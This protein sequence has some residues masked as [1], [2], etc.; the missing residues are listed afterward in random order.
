[1]PLTETIYQKSPV[2]IQNILISAFGY[3]WKKRRFGGIFSK[4]YKAAKNRESYTVQQWTDYQQAELQKLLLHAQAKVPFY[5]SSFDEKG[6]TATD[7]QNLDLGRLE[8]LPVLTKEQLRKFCTTTLISTTKESNTSFFSSSG[9]T[10][11]PVKILYSHSMHQKWFSIFE[12]RIRNWA[13]VSSFI[14]RGMIGGRRIVADAS[15]TPPFYRYNYFEK[16]AYFS[17]YHISSANA[18]NYLK[19]IEKHKVEYMTGY[20]MSNFFLARFLMENNMQAPE[21]KAVL[22]SSEKLSPEMRQMFLEVYNCKTF[23]SWGSV[24]ACG[25]VSECEHGSLHIN[26][27]AGIIEILDDDL[28]PVPDGVAGDVYCTGLLNFDQPLIRYKI[29]DRMIRSSEPCACGRNMPVIKEIVGRIEDVVIGR[30]GREI[31]RF[32]SIF[33]G[34]EKIKKAQVIQEELGHIHIK[35][36]AETSLTQEEENMIAQRVESQLGEMDISIEEVVSIPLNKNGKF[37]AVISKVKRQALN[38]IT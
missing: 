32:H 8:D 28:K 5:K 34:L 6:I 36:E 16:Q 37:Q 24:E 21:L 17:A 9:S 11:T 1:M 23:D 29:G 3:Q 14:P 25:M 7:I 20:A 12:A 18:S 30:D 13:G 15:N 4:E 10:G 22:P 35:I 26:P 31:V 33:Y 19:G 38:S 2:A 27:D